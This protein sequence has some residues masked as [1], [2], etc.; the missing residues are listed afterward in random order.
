MHGYASNITNDLREH[1]EYLHTLVSVC[2]SGE[3]EHLDDGVIW[4]SHNPRAR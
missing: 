1:A 4:P 2:S 3:Q